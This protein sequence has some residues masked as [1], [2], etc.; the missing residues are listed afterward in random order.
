MIGWL[1][2]WLAV[3]AAG[4]AWAVTGGTGGDVDTDTDTDADTDTDTDAGHSGDPGGSG[5]VTVTCPDCGGVAGQVG[6]E[7]GTP[8]ESGCSGSGPRSVGGSSA[9][10]AT[11]AVALARRQRRSR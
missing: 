1:V 4:T 9:L 11:A 5:A 8:C 3:T 6:D 7:G 2:G 10:V